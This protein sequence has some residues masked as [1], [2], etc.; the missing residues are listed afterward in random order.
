MPRMSAKVIAETQIPELGTGLAVGQVMIF[1]AGSNKPV[2]HATVTYSNPP[3]A[4]R[5][6]KPSE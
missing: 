2:T 4:N 3:D 6:A 5:S 1:S